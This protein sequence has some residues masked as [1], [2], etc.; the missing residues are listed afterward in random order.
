[1]LTIIN[2]LFRLKALHEYF[3][4]PRSVFI[5]YNILTVGQL[6]EWAVFGLVFLLNWNVYTQFIL[7]SGFILQSYNLEEDGLVHQLRQTKF[8]GTWGEAADFAL[9]LVY[10]LIAVLF[11]TP[12]FGL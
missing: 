5:K 6:L 11:L 9:F 12:R 10:S 1:M 7:V 4:F 2:A 3:G 8:F